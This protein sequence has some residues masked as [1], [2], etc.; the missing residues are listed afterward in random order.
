MSFGDYWLIHLSRYHP[1]RGDGQDSLGL[2]NT[3]EHFGCAGFNSL[4]FV[5]GTDVRD[6]ILDFGFGDDARSR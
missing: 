1:A 2:E 4:G 5:P 6:G 3:F